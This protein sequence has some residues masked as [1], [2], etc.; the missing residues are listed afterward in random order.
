MTRDQVEKHPDFTKLLRLLK[1]GGVSYRWGNDY[2]GD[3]AKDEPGTDYLIFHVDYNNYDNERDTN[4]TDSRGEETMNDVQFLRCF[5]NEELSDY[6]GS[7][8]DIE[9]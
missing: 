9:I 1:G 4:L 6:Q 7:N 3:N 2:G 8:G 5:I